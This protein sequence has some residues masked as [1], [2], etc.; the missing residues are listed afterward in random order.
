VM[1]RK[2]DMQ[3]RVNFNS[4]VVVPVNF[5]SCS[6]KIESPVIS[7]NSENSSAVFV[8]PKIS[9]SPDSQNFQSVVDDKVFVSVNPDMSSDKLLSPKIYSPISS[10]SEMNSEQR[11]VCSFESTPQLSMLNSN[12]SSKEFSVDSMSCNHV[13]DS[14]SVVCKSVQTLLSMND[15][16]LEEIYSRMIPGEFC[17]N[18]NDVTQE[19]SNK[20]S[21][22]VQTV[23]Y[24][25]FEEIDVKSTQSIFLENF[26]DSLELNDSLKVDNDS[27]HYNN[28]KCSMTNTTGYLVSCLNLQGGQNPRYPSLQC[29]KTSHAM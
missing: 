16:C 9:V 18:W 19:A 28:N 5:Q 25:N 29:T 1:S 15:P 14:K 20:F 21:R 8:S 23:Y 12:V 2:S 10:E 27:L 7:V 6:D 11:G 13:N 24:G 22:N 4:P 17:F 26:S 3:S